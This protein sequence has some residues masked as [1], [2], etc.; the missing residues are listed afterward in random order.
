MRKYLYVSIII[1]ILGFVAGLPS[2][3]EAQ[4]NFGH[5]PGR[6]KGFFNPEEMEQR[7]KN[8]E[9]LRLL[10]LLETLDL[11]ENQNDRFIAVFSQFRKQS[12][13]IH[14]ELEKEITALAEY[15][16]TDNRKDEVILRHTERVREIRLKMVDSRENFFESIKSILTPEQMGR[17][18][19]FEE[20]F[21]RKMLETI[22][23]FRAPSPE[24]AP[25]APEDEG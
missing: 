7:M 13:E 14:D 5:G 4:H 10:K 3:A 22:R 16:D 6:D 8:L 24:P 12:R 23:G 17:M 1:L 18:V 19:I 20:R 15:L 25:G 2:F 11:D 9:N 21:E